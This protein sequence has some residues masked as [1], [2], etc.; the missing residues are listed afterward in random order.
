MK[1][2]TTRPGGRLHSLVRR[3]LDWWH[4]WDEPPQHER[5]ADAIVE[6]MMHYTSKATRAH[7]ADAE[8][9]CLACLNDKCQDW[10][11]G[12]WLRRLKRSGYRATRDSTGKLTVTANDEMRDAM[13]E[14]RL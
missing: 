4:G 8:C 2:T 5:D 11:N 7:A 6:A 12:Y 3:C 10:S 1:T 13:G 9:W 14:K